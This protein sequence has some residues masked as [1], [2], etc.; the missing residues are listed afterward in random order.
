MSVKLVLVAMDRLSP[1]RRSD[2]M[3]RIQST[4]TSPEMIVRRLVH[5]M[6]Y[7]YRLHVAK[8]P[9]KPDMVLHRLKRIIE[10]RGCFWHQHPGCIDSHIP[11]TRLEYWGPKLECNQRRDAENLQKLKTL[12]WKIL[13][14]WECQLADQPRLQK[15]LQRFLCASP[16][17]SR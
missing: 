12:G 4:D 7:R 3:R 5:C 10:V 11:K 15:R 16:Q 9:G 13:I 2:N 8:F 14:I 17:R 6:G 1:E